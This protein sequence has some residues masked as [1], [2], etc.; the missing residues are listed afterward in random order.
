MKLMEKFQDEKCLDPVFLHG[1][2]SGQYQTGSKTL[3]LVGELVSKR[4]KGFYDKYSK[5][6]FCKDCE[7]ISTSQVI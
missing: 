6:T 3:T 7:D 2:G 1:F 4:E 5:Y